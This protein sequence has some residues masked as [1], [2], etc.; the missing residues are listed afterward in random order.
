MDIKNKMTRNY[1]ITGGAGFIGANF[2]GYLTGCLENQE[3]MNPLVRNSD[4]ERIGHIVILDKLTYAGDRSRI[5][6][7]LGDKVIFEE[8]DICDGLLIEGL[9]T[10]YNINTI[11]NFAAESHVDR[12]IEDQTAFIQTNIVGV[13]TLMTASLDVWASHDHEHLKYIEN[14]RFIQI[15]TDEVYGSSGRDGAHTFTETSA[16]RP[17]N[18]YAATKAS[19]EHMVESFKN[20]Y[21]YPAIILR[22]SNN[23]GLMQNEEKFIPKTLKSIFE[24]RPITIYGD[25]SHQRTWLHVTDH[26]RAISRAIQQAPLG[27]VY[28][29]GGNFEISNRELVALI[30]RLMNEEITDRTVVPEIDYVADRPGHDFRYALDASK[31]EQELGFRPGIGFDEGLVELIRAYLGERDSVQID[32]S[33]ED[34]AI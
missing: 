13:Q 3:S 23:Y 17:R 5:E 1:L 30:V 20:T 32:Q 12:S 15:S 25:G 14:A 10:S 6:K 11:V 24:N 22:P 27:S 18:P 4:E 9:L 7:Y 2:V 16:L 26:C 29:I 19:A 21:D 31:I 8:G 34:K 28:N 33:H